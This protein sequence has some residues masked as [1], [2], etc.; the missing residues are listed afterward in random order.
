MT[1]KETP[2]FDVD[3][4]MRLMDR[5]GGCFVLR[6][7]IRTMDAR[8]VL[9]GPSG[10]GK[11]LTL[12]A[13]AGL[14]T[15]D[16]GF[17]RVNGR[18]LFDSKEKVNLPARKRNVGFLFQDYALFPHMT[19]R[20]NVRFG[21]AR[22]FHRISKEASDRVEELISVCGLERVAKSLPGELSGGQRQRT[23]LARGL[24]AEPEM[25]LLDEPFSALDRPLRLRL[26]QSVFDILQ[27]YGLPLVLVTHDK[28]EMESFAQS[29]AVYDQGRVV[30]LE[31][32]G[33][34]PLDFAGVEA[35]M[36]RA[37]GAEA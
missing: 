36:E 23:A 19:V 17:I 15:P 31:Q 16:E 12:Q 26:R 37:Y 4:R 6:S 2:V 18:T 28:E 10:S 7:R 27:E 32:G 20:E 33:A 21:A 9:F 14:A 3:I 25:L 29:V 35:A 8:L 5:N 30:A 13:I 22:L 34:S 1:D 24:A 11:T